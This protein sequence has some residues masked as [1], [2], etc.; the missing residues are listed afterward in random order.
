V[1]IQ[2]LAHDNLFCFA[3]RGHTIMYERTR[4]ILAAERQ[5]SFDIQSSQPCLV[6]ELLDRSFSPSADLKLRNF[7]AEQAHI[8]NAC[9]ERIELNH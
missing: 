1:C 2:I 8:S 4:L 9:V 3:Q 5:P 6:K 7:R